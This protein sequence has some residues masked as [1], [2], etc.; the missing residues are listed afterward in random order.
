MKKRTKKPS[1]LFFLSPSQPAS[2]QPPLPAGP[3]RLQS[4]LPPPPRASPATPPAHQLARE[5]HQRVRAP[6]RALGG[7]APRSSPWP[8]R[9]PGPLRTLAAQLPPRQHPSAAQRARPAQQRALTLSPLCA[10]AAA[11]PALAHLGHLAQRAPKPTSRAAA[12]SH[13][14]H[15]WASCP[16]AAGHYSSSQKPSLS[17]LAIPMSPLPH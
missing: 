16:A 1:F 3:A 9:A 13:D 14:V 4:A 17:P 8:A 12:R 7:P 11:T 15:A 2:A 5:Q 6:F 10:A